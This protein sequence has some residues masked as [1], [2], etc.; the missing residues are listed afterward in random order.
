MEIDVSP[1]EGLPEFLILKFRDVRMGT[2]KGTVRTFLKMYA[3][4]SSFRAFRVI[5]GVSPVN[6][7]TQTDD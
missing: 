6:I 1:Y 3:Q 5:I 2:S 4:F 7:P